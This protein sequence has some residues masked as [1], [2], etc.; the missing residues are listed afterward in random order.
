MLCALG[1]TALAVRRSR[2]ILRALPKNAS[3]WRFVN[4]LVNCLINGGKYQE[5]IDAPLRWSQSVRD[6][7]RA[8]EPGDWA[9]V[10]INMAEAL[11]N[12]GRWDEALARLA[13]LDDMA[14]VQGLTK[15]GLLLQRAWI[16]AHLGH[17]TAAR[18]LADEARADD[19]PR[20]FHAELHFTR[21]AALA[22]IG[23]QADAIEEVCR[24]QHYAMRASSERNALF[25]LGRLEMS[26]GRLESAEQHFRRGA[27]HSYQAQGAEG[28]LLWGDVLDALHRSTE[29]VAAWQF[30]QQR[31]PE[32]EAAHVATQR[33]ALTEGS[34]TENA[35]AEFGRMR[36][37]WLWN[38]NVEG[39]SRDPDGVS[40]GIVQNERRGHPRAPSAIG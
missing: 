6:G 27:E 35:M 11:Y 9:L 16:L 33:L 12:L 10:E 39:D 24:G 2:A 21:G 5:A 32:S 8:K 1:R 22:S 17:G 26:R 37:R 34:P 3:T 14:A 18:N 31:D 29:A 13:K 38:T 20:A 28:L 40:G 15:S 23:R 7:A 30:A 36:N 25:L 4:A 19:L